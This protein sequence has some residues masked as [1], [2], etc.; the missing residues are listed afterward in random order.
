MKDLIFISVFND[1]VYELALNHLLSLKK[2]NIE[3]Y[4]G[5]TNGKKS[6]NDFKNMGLN[7]EYFEYNNNNEF[8][9]SSNEFN[10]FSL[11]RY[12][13]IIENLKKYNNVWYMDVDTVVLNNL[14][15][16]KHKNNI[17]LILQND[18]NMPCTGCLLCKDLK[19]MEYIYNLISNISKEN[20]YEDND[21]IIFNNIKHMIG[22][23]DT[24]PINEFP[25]GLLYFDEKFIGEKNGQLK[26]IK[27]DFIKNMKEIKF[28][29]ANYMIGNSKKKESLIE[30]NLWFINI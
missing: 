12:K 27:D 3:N 23:F 20:N 5:Y 13:F 28:V 22:K 10:N 29:H 6:Y 2:N 8:K 24:F 19:Q 30:S 4:I 25:N 15:N 18:I 9:W 14:N 17:S 1:G 26:K 16:Y 7:V 21:Q 11:L